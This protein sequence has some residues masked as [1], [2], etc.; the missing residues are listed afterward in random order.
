[1]QLRSNVSPEEGQKNFRRILSE[2]GEQTPDWNEANT[3][4]HII[5]R[6]LIECLGW[7]KTPDIFKLEEPGDNDYRD[8]LLGSPA[9][10]V[11]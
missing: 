9:L 10:T 1:M 5:D 4:F 11:C 3:R 7:Q 8:Y 6:L 2:L